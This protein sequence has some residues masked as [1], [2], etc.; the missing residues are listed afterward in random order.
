LHPLILWNPP[1][2]PFRSTPPV[3]PAGLVNRANVPAGIHADVDQCAKGGICTNPLHGLCQEFSEFLVS[4][5]SSDAIANLWCVVRPTAHMAVNFD[6]IGR[7][8]EHRG[9]FLGPP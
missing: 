9:G 2:L 5:I 3:L 1:Q 4:V 6:V 8:R 7:V